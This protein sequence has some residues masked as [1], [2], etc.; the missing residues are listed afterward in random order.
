MMFLVALQL[1]AGNL[2]FCHHPIDHSTSD[3]CKGCLTVLG[4]V[5][6]VV[7]DFDKTRSLGL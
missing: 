2:E 7:I 6:V 4:V 1:T 3:T 5:L